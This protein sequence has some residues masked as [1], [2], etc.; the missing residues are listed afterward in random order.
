M[1]KALAER[2]EV[3]FLE[4]LLRRPGTKYTMTQS[5]ELWKPK[6]TQRK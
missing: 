5:H 4:G 3:G 6:E 1:R 2:L